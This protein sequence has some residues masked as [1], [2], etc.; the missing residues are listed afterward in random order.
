[1]LS[2]RFIT[3]LAFL[4]LGAAFVIGSLIQI[5]NGAT[6]V[7]TFVALAVGIGLIVIGIDQLRNRR[8]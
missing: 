7:L 8:K 5:I 4:F 1:M 2:P 3:E 6:T